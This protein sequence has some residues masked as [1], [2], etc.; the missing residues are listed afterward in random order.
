MITAHKFASLFAKPLTE[1]EAPGYNS[2]VFR[3]QDLKSV[4]AAVSAGGRT[5]AAIAEQEKESMPSGTNI[6]WVP[7]TEDVTPPKGIVNGSQLEKEL[8][9]VFANA[10]MFNPDMAENRG[11]GPA[12]RSR[13]RTVA[14][15]LS[16][17]DGESGELESNNEMES[18]K[19]EIGVARPEAGALVK[20]AR[21]MFNAVEEF[22][23]EWRGVGA[24]SEDEARDAPVIGDSRS[25]VRD[26]KSK[27]TSSHGDEEEE[28]R[29]KRR[30]R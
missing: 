28:A 12:L 14:G 16:R 4:K 20:D 18:V 26:A 25:R 6:M 19:F 11:L 2:M 13:E 23:D 17:Q 29:P 24:V 10:V 9:R 22:L 15:H 7:E 3:V 1:R 21:D 30:R 8:I 5:I 27:G